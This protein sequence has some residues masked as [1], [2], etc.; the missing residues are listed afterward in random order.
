[1][2]TSPEPV[3]EIIKTSDFNEVSVPVEPA[4]QEVSTDRVERSQKNNKEKVVPQSYDPL[5]SLLQ[6]TREAMTEKQALFLDSSEDANAGVKDNEIPETNVRGDLNEFQSGP[7]D[8]TSDTDI[9]DIRQ[10]VQS[11]EQSQ[12]IKE[13]GNGIHAVV[14]SVSPEPSQAEEVQVEI[15]VYS[16]APH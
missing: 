15:P 11:E 8:Y 14:D 9:E 16:G 10:T 3:K 1:M 4:A 2:E 6:A 7:E 12:D 5:L 13:V